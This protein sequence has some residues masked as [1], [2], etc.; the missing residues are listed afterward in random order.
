MQTS[1]SSERAD[2]SDNVE[3]IGF[4]VAAQRPVPETAPPPPVDQE[5]LLSIRQTIAENNAKIVSTLQTDLPKFIQQISSA[6][7]KSALD[8][9]HTNILGTFQA[10]GTILAVRF[11]LL[12]SLL[13][14]FA[15]AWT[16]MANPT[17]PAI[18][19][20]VSY[21]L[22]TVLPLVWLDRGGRRSPNA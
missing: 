10:I 6:A 13:G 21:I 8:A 14:A 19:I 18:I 4:K 3:V 2:E 16:A 22:L 7:V 15:L 5:I 12:L 11:I 1:S 17:Y 9:S 20:L